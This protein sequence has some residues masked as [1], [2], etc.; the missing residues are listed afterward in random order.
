MIEMQERGSG[1]RV[2]RLG[3]SDLNT[4]ESYFLAC[5]KAYGLRHSP[6]EDIKD[7]RERKKFNII[8]LIS[9]EDAV[10]NIVAGVQVDISNFGTDKILAY[11]HHAFVNSI[12]RRK[13]LSTLI[14][15]EALSLASSMNAEFAFAFI[16]KGEEVPL[17]AAVSVGFSPTTDQVLLRF[18]DDDR[19]CMVVAKRLRGSS[20]R[21]LQ[22]P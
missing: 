20:S 19:S 10:G 5:N 12:N 22:R 16:N 3:L 15:T 21:L 18:L 6:S 9:A 8:S 17:K 4:L 11:M 1:F 7:L 14:Y 13:G 2:L